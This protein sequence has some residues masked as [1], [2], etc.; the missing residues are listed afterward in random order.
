M[1]KFIDMVCMDI[2][3]PLYDGTMVPTHVIDES[4]REAK[5]DIMSGLI[6][7]IWNSDY[8]QVAFEVQSLYRAGPWVYCRG[9]IGEFPV[10]NYALSANG[11]LERNEN[12]AT[13]FSVRSISLIYPPSTRLSR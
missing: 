11:I 6:V 8:T 13:R 2:S 12:V 3:K 10:G 5:V 4:L 9:R 7:G 1:D